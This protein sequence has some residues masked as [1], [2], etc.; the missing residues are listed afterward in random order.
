M[1]MN[2]V[3]HS[4]TKFTLIELLV[5][6]AIIAIIASLLLPVLGRARST[7]R[8][9]KCVNNLGQLGKINALY[10]A[11]YQDYFPN[12]NYT[13][14]SYWFYKSST[15]LASYLNWGRYVGNIYYGGIDARDAT[16]ITYG[17]F[18]CPE[19]SV[20]NIE[21]VREGMLVN[22]AYSSGMFFSLAL[23]IAFKRERI[24][25]WGVDAIKATSIR[26]P[27]V[28]VHMSDSGGTGSVDYRCRWDEYKAENVPAL[29]NGSANFLYADSHVT[30]IKWDA[31]PSS[32]HGNARVQWDGPV[33]NPAAK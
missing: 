11:D 22:K 20:A 3:P 33:W 5:V 1:F 27:S 31:F 17:P 28:L 30:Q 21:L 4:K 16:E 18:I 7:A 24:T 10:I 15:A 26:K 19:V 23:N 12:I 9:M 6:I 2:T 29:H 14:S 25:Q 8:G 13:A 32:N